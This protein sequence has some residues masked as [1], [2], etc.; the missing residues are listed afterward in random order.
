MTALGLVIT[1]A[2]LERFT[3]AQTSADIDLAITGI[4]LTDDDFLVAPTLTAL[5]GEF[6]RLDTISGQTVG[7]NTVHLTI[8][9]ESSDTYHVTGF[10]LFLD[11]GTL[12]AVYGQA[13]TLVEKATASTILLA[14]DLRFPPGQVADITFGDANF[15]YPPATETVKGV[16]ELASQAEVD[17]GT[18]HQRI[19]TP[20]T[21]AQRLG[22]LWTATLALVA[23]Y[24]PLT[25][26]VATSGLA[27]GGG[28]LT[29]NRTISVPAASAAEADAGA[30][31]TKA[32]TPAS[33]VNILASLAAKAASAITVTGG[34]L[35]TGGGNLTANRSLT[36]TAATGAEIAAGT[37]ADKAVTPA[38]IAA[39][40]QTFGANASIRGLGG[41]I[42][43]MG[44]GTIVWGG[45]V[46][47][48]F[49]VAF[50]NACN[51]VLVT[52]QDNSD[53]GAGDE[54]DETWWVDGASVTASGFV[55]ASDGDNA[56]VSFGWVAWGH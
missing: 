43:K 21:L 2:G 47:V 40:P 44:T 25:R 30:L 8:R 24:V 37:A 38:A 32:L 46:T 48:T 52:L 14:L 31:T 55:L 13:G 42:T 12:F 35:V 34:G 56:A 19:V 11:D 51:R 7:P 45:S 1:N 16:A 22:A 54:G 27:T 41:A 26:Q 9:D 29:A 17:I 33:L 6:K 20:L 39:V 5:P 3:A 23:N 15:L 49:P 4:G 18:D 53:S 50:P 10:G 28:D 36:V